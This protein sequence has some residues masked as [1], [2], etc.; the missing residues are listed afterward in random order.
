MDEREITYI[1]VASESV[2]VVVMEHS[3]KARLGNVTYTRAVLPRPAWF[4]PLP[5]LGRGLL[6]AD[7]VPPDTCGVRGPGRND[8]LQLRSVLMSPI[9]IPYGHHAISRQRLLP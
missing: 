3:S 5:E 1:Q 9:W 6:P 2:H 7:A 8:H 4:W